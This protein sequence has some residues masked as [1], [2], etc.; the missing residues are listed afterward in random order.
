MTNGEERGKLKHL[1][2]HIFYLIGLQTKF[3]AQPCM[4][5]RKSLIL[6]GESTRETFSLVFANSSQELLIF[7]LFELLLLNAFASYFEYLH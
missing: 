1:T 4:E 2:C 7:T 3:N 6:S 5:I